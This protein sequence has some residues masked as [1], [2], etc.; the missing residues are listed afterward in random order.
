MSGICHFSPPY[1]G[2]V[3][4]D[5]EELAEPTRWADSFLTSAVAGVAKRHPDLALHARTVRGVTEDRAIAG[6][7]AC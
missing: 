3:D 4:P 2:G 6:V 1:G 5:E 7:R